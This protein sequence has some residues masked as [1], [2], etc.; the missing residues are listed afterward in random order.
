MSEA[1]DVTPQ[2]IITRV[3]VDSGAS[4]HLLSDASFFE[5]LQPLAASREVRLGNSTTLRAK[6]FGPASLIVR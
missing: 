6:G 2:K 5:E 3:V 4:H 1:P